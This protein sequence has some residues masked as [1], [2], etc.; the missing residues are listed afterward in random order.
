MNATLA[1]NPVVI[2]VRVSMVLIA[3]IALRG[4]QNNER[5]SLGSN[6]GRLVA[7]RNNRVDV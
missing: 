5:I 4:D 2:S 7:C 1:M 6:H 3:P